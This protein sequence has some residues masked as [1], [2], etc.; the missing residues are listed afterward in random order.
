VAL[1][2]DGK[3]VATGSHDDRH[4][5]EAATGKIAQTFKGH[6]DKVMSIAGWESPRHR[7]R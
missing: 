6:K 2:G 4:S 7:V 5:L 1:S 3:V